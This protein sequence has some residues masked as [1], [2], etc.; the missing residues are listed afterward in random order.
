M[1][2]KP[3]SKGLELLT[4]PRTLFTFLFSG[5]ALGVMGNAVY[6]LLTNWLT[7]ANF[8]VVGIAIG[9]LLVLLAAMWFLNRLAHRLH[10][11][12]PLPD[13]KPPKKRRGIIFLVSNEPTIR[14]ALEWHGETLTWCR[15][16]CSEQSMP[17]ATKLKA[18]LKEQGKD[19]EL[20][21]VN[22]VLDPVECRNAV[23]EIYAKLRPDLT[24]SDVIL[25]FTGMTAIA[26]VGA[27]LACL[28]E[29]RA[30]QYTPGVFDK[31][32]KA[33]QPRDPVE[34]VLHWGLLRLPQDVAATH[35]GRGTNVGT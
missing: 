17:L 23:D 2:K 16:I 1:S 5:I 18:E 12:P 6:Q 31:D 34:I 10:P 3:F 35:A 14:K 26:S 29:Q 22:D 32:L 33:I 8:A 4:E 25:D 11:A 28:D 21:L 9:S 30:I 15:L 13:K 20:A 24:E 19:V 27:V 7:T